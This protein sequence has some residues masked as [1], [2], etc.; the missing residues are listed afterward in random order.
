MLEHFAVHRCRTIC[1]PDSVQVFHKQLAGGSLTSARF[2]Y[3]CRLHRYCSL[4][5]GPNG[6]GLS[7]SR[8]SELYVRPRICTLPP[9]R[10][11][12]TVL[13]AVEQPVSPS[14]PTAETINNKRRQVSLFGVTFVGIGL[15]FFNAKTSI[16]YS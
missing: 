6:H 7:K 13:S 2:S 1:M 9:V 4:D 10:F 14:N 12:P 15:F 11:C 8:L 3:Y 16:T 5:S